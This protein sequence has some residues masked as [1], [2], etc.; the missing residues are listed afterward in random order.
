MRD[1]SKPFFDVSE[2]AAAFNG[3]CKCLQKDSYCC[4]ADV[5]LLG[6]RLSQ[7]AQSEGFLIDSTGDV[8]LIGVNLQSF[9]E[10]LLTQ[11]ELTKEQLRFYIDTEL[12]KL[13]NHPLI[14]FFE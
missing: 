7:M 3:I 2:L 9:I 14:N 1:Y 6:K 13:P 12:R 5:F 8:G 4:P 11:K 10:F